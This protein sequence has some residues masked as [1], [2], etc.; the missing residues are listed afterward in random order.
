MTFVLKHLDDDDVDFGLDVH[1]VVLDDGLFGQTS[2]SR[3]LGER[4]RIFPR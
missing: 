3:Y 4:R 2:S 1:F